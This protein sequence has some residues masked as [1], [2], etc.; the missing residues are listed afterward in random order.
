MVGVKDEIGSLDESDEPYVCTTDD[1]DIARS[2][3]EFKYVEQKVVC[4]IELKDFPDNEL[5]LID[6]PNPRLDLELVDFREFSKFEPELINFSE[7]EP[8]P[9]YLPKPKS[10]EIDMSLRV[11]SSKFDMSKK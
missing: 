2:L 6:F 9:E 8:E 1:L 5:E 11:G 7:V 4:L 10:L 3:T